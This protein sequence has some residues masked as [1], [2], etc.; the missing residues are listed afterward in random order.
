MPFGRPVRRSAAAFAMFEE[1]REETQVDLKSALPHLLARAISWAEAEATRGADV[2]REL[3]ERERE[4]ARKVGVTHP[5]RIRVVAVA[6]LGQPQSRQASW[7]QEWLALLL[8]T[9]CL[10][11]RCQYLLVREHTIRRE[12]P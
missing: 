9:Q 11:A 8:D 1:G 5:E 12:V 7:I 10:S 6:A 3:S 4:L 2:S